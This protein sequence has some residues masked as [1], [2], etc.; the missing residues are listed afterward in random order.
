MGF[1]SY[2]EDIIKLR[3]DIIKLRDEAA[4]F[5]GLL[6]NEI[7]QATSNV[8][9]I[10]ATMETGRLIMSYCAIL[11]RIIC[12]LDKLLELATEPDII[13]A[14]ELARLQVERDEAAAEA[15]GLRQKLADSNAAQRRA[16]VRV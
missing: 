2:G 7:R 5:R 9:H 12:R 6:D 1:I 8:K 4:H 11:D 15:N 16:V 10:D 13:A 3:E 14:D